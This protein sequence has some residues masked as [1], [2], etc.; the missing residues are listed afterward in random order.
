VFLRLP[1]AFGTLLLSGVAL[2]GAA[3]DDETDTTD[4]SVTVTG[5][6]VDPAVFLGT[7]ACT[8]GRARSYRAELISVESSDV[9]GVSDVVGCGKPVL[10]SSGVVPGLR[11]GARVAI[12]AEAGG[13]EDPAWT[14]ECGLDGDGAALAENFE[15]VT[16]RGCTP[17]DQGAAVSK[18]VV[19]LSGSLGELACTA[20]GGS[21][22]TLQIE[23]EAP[24]GLESVVVPCETPTHTFT[25]GLVVGDS[26]AFT[27]TAADPEGVVRWGARCQ[28][29]VTSATTFASCSV[30]SSGATVVLPVTDLVNEAGLT[31]GASTTS[32]RVS[33]SGPVDVGQKIVPCDAA[34]T[35]RGRRQ[36]RLRRRSRPW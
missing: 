13:S 3:C 17:I 15:Q 2:A 12:F 28:A 11:Y 1:H 35:D 33:V 4:R 20:D 32:A 8:E 9:L 21:I 18:V 36:V 22:V 30:L 24:S 5:I 29:E 7:L 6:T 34:A 27:I 26:H 25:E 16:V 10:F 31:C 14:T 19:D 23:P